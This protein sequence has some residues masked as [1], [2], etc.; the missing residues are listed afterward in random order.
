MQITLSRQPV[1]RVNSRSCRCLMIDAV[2][3]E[4]AASRHDTR[5]GTVTA[6][7]LLDAPGLP[8]LLELVEH[9]RPSHEIHLVCPGQPGLIRLG[10]TVIT[11]RMLRL[12]Q[13]VRASFIALGHSLG[14]DA[15]LVLGGANVGLGQDGQAFL[16]AL[17]DLV[18]AEVSA[19]V[20]LSPPVWRSAPAEPLSS[21]AAF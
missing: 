6:G 11:L 3:G 16:E 4:H 7:L 5:T 1:E 9:V 8:Q 15:A 12:D 10:T 14:T 18:Q 13:R 17:A 2:T 19:L 20:R 21:P